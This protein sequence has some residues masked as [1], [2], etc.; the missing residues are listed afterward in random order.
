MVIII[1]TMIL[2]HGPGVRLSFVISTGPEGLFL[3]QI[4]ID[5][6]VRILYCNYTI[7]IVA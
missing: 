3:Q 6:K 4:Q 2:M 1:I 7:V 5:Y